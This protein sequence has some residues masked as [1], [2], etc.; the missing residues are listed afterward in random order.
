MDGDPNTEIIEYPENWEDMKGKYLEREKALL[1]KVLERRKVTNEQELYAI[2]AR[3]ILKRATRGS[4]DY[5]PL[6]DRTV[7]TDPKSEDIQE[8]KKTLLAE[9]SAIGQRILGRPPIPPLPPTSAPA[10]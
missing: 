1:Q 2:A 3:T 7:I 10:A 8:L 6:K 4:T 9:I 5:K